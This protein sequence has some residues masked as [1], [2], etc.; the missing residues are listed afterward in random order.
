VGFYNGLQ[1]PVR[2]P[3]IDPTNPDCSLSIQANISGN[4]KLDPEKSK[5]YTVGLVFE[6]IKDHSVSVDLWQIK[7]T[8]E[9]TNLD[10]NYLLANQ[11]TYAGFIRRDAAGS[12]TDVDLPYVN[13]AGTNVKGIDLDFRGKTNF[14]EQ[15]LVTYG[16]AATHFDYFKV[17]PAPTAEVENYN[18]TYSQPRFRGN[19]RV[20]WEKGPWVSELSLNHVGGF[21]N[22]PTPSSVCSAPA[23]LSA[24]CTVEPWTTFGLYIGYKGFKNTELSLFVDNLLDEPPAFDYRAAVNSQ[25]T[26]WS[27]LYSNALGRTFAVRLKYKF[28]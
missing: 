4:P 15:G 9:I 20:G 3:V 19:A 21:L 2:C 23:V 14:G 16:F 6:P 11:A 10:I 27:P 7:R 22:K 13:L 17:Q 25:T 1:D 24:Y 18:G 12:I 26:A 28:F 8:N 5:S